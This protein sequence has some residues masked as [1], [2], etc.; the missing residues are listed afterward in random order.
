MVRLW[1]CADAKKVREMKDHGCEVYSVAFH[2]DGKALVSGDCKGVIKQWDAGP[3]KSV[4]EIDAR[5]MYA[6]CALQELGGARFMTFDA[7]GTTLAVAGALGA[8][9][10][11]TAGP[12]VMLFDW[13][14]GKTTH[15]IKLGA[16]LEGYVYDLSFHPDGFLMGVL[17]GQPGQGKLFFAR[18]G[19]TAPFFL[20]PLPN[21][22]SLAIQPGFKRMIVTTTNA[23]SNG[24]GR[25]LDKDKKY[26]G[27]FSLLH[28]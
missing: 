13:A 9:G 21:P 18:P 28:V 20:A 23:G 27:N 1:S 2:P 22:H 10:K 5:S 26:P 8:P 14:S 4:R 3:G 15:T 25:P 16:P 12:C 19:E 17:S 6:V 7:K 24:N 11:G